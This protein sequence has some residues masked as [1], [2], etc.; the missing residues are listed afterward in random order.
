SV[1]AIT[2]A[3]CMEWRGVR[4]GD[5]YALRYA[6]GATNAYYLLFSF[7]ATLGVFAVVLL[8]GLW[9][10]ASGQLVNT[11]LPLIWFAFGLFLFIAPL[12]V[13][14]RN[15]WG[16]LAPRPHAALGTLVAVLQSL[17]VVLIV[18]LDA[19][20]IT[21]FNSGLLAANLNP[22]YWPLL[23]HRLIGNVAWTALF[24]AGYAALKLRST[25]DDG[26]RGFQAWAA[27]INLRIGLWLTLLMPVVGFVLILVISHWQPGYFTNLVGGD[28]G[29][30]LVLQEVFVAVV[31]IGGNVALASED[32]RAPRLG[33][34]AVLTCTAA[35]VVA[36]LPSSVLQEPVYWIRY[37]GLGVAVLVTAVHLLMRRSAVRE[38]ASLA[39][40]PAT[41]ARM[42]S[43]TRRALVAAGVFSL[44]TALLMGVIKEKARSPFTVYGELTQ[45]AAQQPYNPSPGIYP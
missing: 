20:L 33:H 25:Q 31:L 17:F 18:G 10:N 41:P 40:A 44:A 43:A 24:F 12:L 27:R 37:V 34:P 22:P 15:T 5:E 6:R 36:C 2:L 19:Y 42:L 35:M 4:R 13:L 8:V 7:G 21:P 1:G 45:S 30:M 39:T 29:W 11:F 16:K 28:N 23:L 14:Y 38:A 9:G 3:T 26:E 32:G